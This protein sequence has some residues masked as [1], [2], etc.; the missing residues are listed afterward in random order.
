MTGVQTCALPISE[1]E[2]YHRYHPPVK[3]SKSFIS[4]SVCYT[5]CTMAQQ[6]GATGIIAMTNSGYTAFRISSQRP[7]SNVFIFTDNMQM[8]TTLNLVWGV[9]TFHYDR[10]ESSEETI[11]DI[12][13][14]L[15]Q[16]ALVNSGDLLI[17]VFSTPL[18]KR[19]MANTIKLHLIDRKS[20]RLNSSHIPLSRMP[21]SA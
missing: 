18:E 8:L 19:G 14:F 6:A 17:N 13:D 9:R 1:Q 10:Y 2:I 4:D 12:K 5:A 20:T 11:R 3:D 7:K 21:S 16:K 15:K